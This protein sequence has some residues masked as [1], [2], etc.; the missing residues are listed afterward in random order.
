MHFYL[1]LSTHTHMHTSIITVYFKWLRASITKSHEFQRTASHSSCFSL[2][3]LFIY[4]VFYNICQFNQFYRA[5][6]IYKINFHIWETLQNMETT[7]FCLSWNLW[8]I[9]TGLNTYVKNKDG[10]I[11]KQSCHP[12]NNL[13]AWLHLNWWI[14]RLFIRIVGLCVPRCC[15][16]PSC[17]F[18]MQRELGLHQNINTNS[19]HHATQF[20]LHH[21]TVFY[22]YFLDPFK[23]IQYKTLISPLM[24]QSYA[25]C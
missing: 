11:Y 12:E 18:E 22:W 3:L 10:D 8:S 5:I 19:I 25:T 24:F 16:R 7:L 2:L 1:I 21:A 6:F 14:L 17:R 13:E 20:F 23:G 15:R 4:D 9:S